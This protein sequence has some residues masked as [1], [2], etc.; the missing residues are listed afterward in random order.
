MTKFDPTSAAQGPSRCLAMSVLGCDVTDSRAEPMGSIVE[1]MLDRGHRRVAYAVVSIDDRGGAPGKHFA[2]P[3]SRLQFFD[4]A[5]GS[6]ITA[7]SDIAHATL[8]ATPGFDRDAWPETADASWTAPGSTLHGGGIAP[9]AA[10]RS[11][12]QSITM[13]PLQG[14]PAAASEPAPTQQDLARRR[15]TRLIGVRV[16]DRQYRVIA[17]VQDLVFDLQRATVEGLVLAVGQ[18]DFGADLVVLV[19]VESLVLDVD[20]GVF[21]LPSNRDRLL[22]TAKPLTAIPPW[23]GSD[24]AHSGRE[25]LIGSSPPRPANAEP[26]ARGPNQPDVPAANTSM[27]YGG[28]TDRVR[29]TILDLASSSRQRKGEPRLHLRVRTDTGR[30]VAALAAELGNKEQA[31]LGLAVGQTIELSGW[32]AIQGPHCMLILGS[33]VVGKRTLRIDEGPRDQIAMP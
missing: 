16:V 12:T 30:E 15:L 31:A 23:N 28:L 10:T 33:I 22:R 17:A 8:M 3:C 25:H 29:G 21:V 19:P 6:P 4:N 26:S 20:D 14:A 24:V 5:A 27:G 18:D 13:S 7:S 32:W 9:V 11:I 1:F 2:V